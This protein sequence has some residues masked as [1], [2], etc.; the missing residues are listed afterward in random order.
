MQLCNLDDEHILKF[1]NLLVS[2]YRYVMFGNDDLII[3]NIKNFEPEPTRQG[4][5]KN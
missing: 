2:V 4:D 3:E 5:D 1:N